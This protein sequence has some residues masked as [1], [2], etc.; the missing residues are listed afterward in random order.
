VF[1]AAAVAMTLGADEVVGVQHDFVEALVPVEVAQ[2]HQWQL[3][4]G[5]EQQALFLVQFDAGEGGEVFFGEED[6][7]GFAQPLVLFGADAVEEGQVLAHP[8]PGVIGNRVL[9]QQ[10][11]ATPG[12]EGPHRQLLRFGFGGRAAKAAAEHANDHRH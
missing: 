10:A 1:D 7:A 6:H 2:I 5:G 4:L 12:A 3:R 8:L 9:G 11:P